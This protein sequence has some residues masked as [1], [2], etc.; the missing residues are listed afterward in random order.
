MHLIFIKECN[1]LVMEVLSIQ[2]GEQ[3][4]PEPIPSLPLML[5]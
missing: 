4:P 2:D 1:E 5:H 3:T